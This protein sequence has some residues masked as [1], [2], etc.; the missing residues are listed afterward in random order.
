V[1]SRGDCVDVDGDCK[2]WMAVGVA[3]A[4]IA[5]GYIDCDESVE[6]AQLQQLRII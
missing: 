1:I 6:V 5:D 4:V 2:V 3:A